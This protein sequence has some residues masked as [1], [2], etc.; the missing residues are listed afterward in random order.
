[1]GLFDT[2]LGGIFGGGAA[3]QAADAQKW[4]VYGQQLQAEKQF[5]LMK[6]LLDPYIGL[7]TQYAVPGAQS[8]IQGVLSSYG[9]RPNKTGTNAGPGQGSTVGQRP[10][11][12]PAAGAGYLQTPQGPT[13]TS[14]APTPASESTPGIPPGT[15]GYSGAL[16]NALGVTR[17]RYD[18]AKQALLARA[19]MENLP[20]A[21]VTAALA[22]L[23]RMHAKDAGEAELA[24]QREGPAALLAAIG[25][26][27]GQGPSLAGSQGQLGANLTGQ[28]AA[29]QSALSNLLTQ[30]QFANA[31]G[32]AQFLGGG[33][34]QN[35]GSW[36][37]H[38]LF[39]S[40]R[41]SVPGPGTAPP[42]SPVDFWTTWPTW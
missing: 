1:M 11:T 36:L 5:N 32:L 30:Q 4:Q 6:Q 33:A 20:P 39:G 7:Y 38:A 10:V 41:P 24:M 17:D 13:A 27:L 21:A 42:I 23:E 35:V 26:I 19:K 34:G 28:A 12:D 15:W 29:G 18:R 2:L 37:Q 3:G 14:P 9:Y 8:A 25:P 31:G 40:G 16:G 22:E